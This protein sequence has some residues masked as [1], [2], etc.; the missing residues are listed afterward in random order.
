MLFM[1]S[2][3]PSQDTCHTVFRAMNCWLVLLLRAAMCLLN[4][5]KLLS[6]TGR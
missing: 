3:D 1:P 6:S 2:Q 4:A 5:Q